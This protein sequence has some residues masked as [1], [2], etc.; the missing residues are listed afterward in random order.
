[1]LLSNTKKTGFTL[2]ELL[3]VISIMGL[4]SSIVI[5]SVQD[6]RRKARNS[7]TQSTVGQYLKAFELIKQSGKNFDIT[8]PGLNLAANNLYCLG[9]NPPT[10]TNCG[11]G[12]TTSSVFN[13]EINNYI[14]GAPNPTKTPIGGYGSMFLFSDNSTF[15]FYWL[16]EGTGNK[17]AFGGSYAA[18]NTGSYC[19][20]AGYKLSL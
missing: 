15:T 5:T 20:L 18:F 19:Y 13:N 1:M 3:V 10:T 8:T 4:M 17:C 7:A 16:L 2:I 6:A 11:S 14:V 9:N 12:V